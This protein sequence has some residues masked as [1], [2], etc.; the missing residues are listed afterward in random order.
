MGS[1]VVAPALTYRAL[2]FW[3]WADGPLVHRGE[4]LLGAGRDP[5]ALDSL[6]P[7]LSSLSSGLRQ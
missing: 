5:R 1:G 6:F 4:L 3:V 7:I 2:F